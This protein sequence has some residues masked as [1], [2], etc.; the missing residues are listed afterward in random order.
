MSR[1]EALASPPQPRGV[2]A[3]IILFVGSLALYVGVALWTGQTMMLHPTES[4]AC[5]SAW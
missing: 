5:F 1:A 4:S 3:P 2:T